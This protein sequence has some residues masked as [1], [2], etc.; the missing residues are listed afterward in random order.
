M[1]KSRSPSR[2]SSSATWTEHEILQVNRARVTSSAAR[3]RMARKPS[4][5]AGAKRP[6][7]K[8]RKAISCLAAGHSLNSAT[9]EPVRKSA[10]GDKWNFCLTAG[11]IGPRIRRDDEQTTAPEPHTGI[12]GKGGVGRRQRRDDAG[13]VGRSFR[14]PSEPDHDVEGSTAR[15]GGRCVRSKRRQRRGSTGHRR[16]IAARQDRR[17]DAGE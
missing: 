12:Q 4:S 5:T 14:R 7:T 16:E 6:R 10:Q 9:R 13:A 15:R 3:A 11:K 1:R 8:A 2:S 17:A